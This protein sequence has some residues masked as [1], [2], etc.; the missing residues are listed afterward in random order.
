VE[1][2]GGFKGEDT[3]VVDVEV[4]EVVEFDEKD[5]DVDTEVG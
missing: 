4:G 5:T 1:P 2:I 3:E